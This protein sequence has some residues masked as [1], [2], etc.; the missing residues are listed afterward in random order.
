M[1]ENPS[2]ECAAAVLDTFHLI[3]RTV[4]PE[5]HKKSP[6]ELSIQ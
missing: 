4:G 5:S 6:P 3:M 1:T 2:Q